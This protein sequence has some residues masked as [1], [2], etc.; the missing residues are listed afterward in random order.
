MVRTT[1]LALIGAT[2]L[3]SPAA[4]AADLPPPLPVPVVQP[5]VVTSGWYLRGDV[6][7]GQKSFSDFQHNQTN[8]AFIWPASWRIDQKDMADTAFIGFGVGYAWNNWL[9]FDVTGEY[10]MKEAFRVTGSYTEF[11]PGGRCF[12]V[13]EGH[14]SNWL[15][16]ANAYV[17]LGTWWCLTPF[18]GAGIGTAY[19]R[20]TG[21]QDIG[22]ISDGTTGFGYAASDSSKWSMAWA[23][24]AGVAY[25]VTNNFKVELAY[26]YV[27][28]G[29]IDTPVIDCASGGCGAGN[30]PRAYYSFT[31]YYSQD[32]KI[33]M[34]WMLQP[35]PVYAPPPLIR[36]G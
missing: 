8:P 29:T 2:A 23:L 25:N 17:D 36:K 7:V 24:H 16:L 14:H 3:L 33:G 34:R 21:V 22:L 6:G 4:N 19:H 15:V 12:D 13:Y 30:G 1:I 9:R 31:N 11:C 32:L 5:V 28:M 35:E 18:V 27:N 10:R 26:R 20:F